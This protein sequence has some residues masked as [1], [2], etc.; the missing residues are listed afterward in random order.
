MNY[1]KGVR[2][3]ICL[4]QVFC[5]KKNVSL[6]CTFNEIDKSQTIDNYRKLIIIV[7]I[8]IIF[9][10]FSIIEQGCSSSLAFELQSLSE[11]F[12]LRHKFPDM[13]H[14]RQ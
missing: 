7:I 13:E 11:S 5:D 3:Y 10:Q 6:T 12:P 9:V 4:L 1:E 8:F 14:I 2:L